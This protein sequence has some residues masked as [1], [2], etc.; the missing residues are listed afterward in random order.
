MSTTLITAI[1]FAAAALTTLAF[2]PQAVKSWRSRST[3][4]V[5]LGM[6]LLLVTGIVLWLAYGLLRADLP[7][8]AANAVSLVLAG[9]ILVSKLRFG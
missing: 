3:S 8:I 9:S 5:S 7:I 1:G 2:L 6:A 4:D